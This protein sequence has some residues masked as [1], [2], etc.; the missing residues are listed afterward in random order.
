MRPMP[1]TQPTLF[2][3]Q[4]WSALSGSQRAKALELLKVLLKEA[5]S[6]TDAGS[7]RRDR[8]VGDDQ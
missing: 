7:K 6:A 2:K 5:M 8:E 3:I 1:P 4:S